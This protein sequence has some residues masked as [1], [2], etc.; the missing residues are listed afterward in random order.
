MSLLFCFVFYKIMA[1][2][3]DKTMD[4]SS[5]DSLLLYLLLNW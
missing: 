5:F 2:Q 3:A 1:K 4:V